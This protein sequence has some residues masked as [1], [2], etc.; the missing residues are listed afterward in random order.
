MTTSDDGLTAKRSHSVRAGDD[1]PIG[2]TKGIKKATQDQLQPIISEDELSVCK[3]EGSPPKKA[4]KNKTKIVSKIAAQK[5]IIK[6]SNQ[7][8]IAVQTEEEDSLSEGANTVEEMPKKRTL[9]SLYND[10][11]KPVVAEPEDLLLEAEE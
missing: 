8:I 5:P 4:K 2:T 10:L 9:H 1:S 3:S 6:K 7:P 11:K